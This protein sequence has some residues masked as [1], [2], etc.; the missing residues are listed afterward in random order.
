[1]KLGGSTGATATMAKNHRILKHFF[2]SSDW[3]SVISSQ[4]YFFFFS[5][6]ALNM[7][8]HN[9]LAVPILLKEQISVEDR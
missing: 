1:M 4:Y 7:R 8:F 6:P 9:S 3:I 5:V 2:G